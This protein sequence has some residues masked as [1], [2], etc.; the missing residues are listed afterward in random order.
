MST[1]RII[2]LALAAFMAGS[3][4]A[5]TEDTSQPDVGEAFADITSGETAPDGTTTETSPTEPAPA[6]K[7][8]EQADQDDAEALTN[9]R[10]AAHS[11]DRAAKSP[12]KGD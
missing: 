2:T 3:L 12:L 10:T 11:N 7:T 6:A 4:V 9:R 8:P 1:S 5:C